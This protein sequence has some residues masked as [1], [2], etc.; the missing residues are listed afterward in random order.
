MCSGFVAPMVFVLPSLQAYHSLRTLS[1]GIFLL[2]SW[3]YMPLDV[4]TIGFQTCMRYPQ[5][6][7]LKCIPFAALFLSTVM[8][9][10]YSQPVLGDQRDHHSAHPPLE[11]SCLFF[12]HSA[13]AQGL[14]QHSPRPNLPLPLLRSQ[15]KLLI[16]RGA[17]SLTTLFKVG[18]HFILSKHPSSIAAALPLIFQL[19]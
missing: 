10:C 6:K 19:S 12:S 2:I 13:P 7:I 4:H 11:A 1:C 14:H 9:S 15:C 3:K 8:F 18:F 5:L 16:P 17:P